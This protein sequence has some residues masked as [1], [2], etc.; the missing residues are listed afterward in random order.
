[1]KSGDRYWLLA[2]CASTLGVIEL[3]PGRETRCY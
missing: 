1:M 3:E 2:N